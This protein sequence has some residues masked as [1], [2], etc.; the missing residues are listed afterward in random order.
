MKTVSNRIVCVLLEMSDITIMLTSIYMPC[1][2][3]NSIDDVY[4][5]TLSELQAL[6]LLH[7]PTYVCYLWW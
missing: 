3:Y 6:R 2:S 5:E 1:D 7:D 4:N